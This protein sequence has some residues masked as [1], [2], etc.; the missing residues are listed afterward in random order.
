MADPLFKARNLTKHFDVTQSFFQKLKG[1]EKLKV[2]AV[3]GIDF[4]I[5]Q[6][7]NFSIVGESGCGKTTVGKLM[8]RLL[9][10]T[11]G[12]MYMKDKDIADMDSK[13]QLKAYRRTTQIIYQDPFSALDPRDRIRTILEEPLMIHNLGDTREERTDMVKEALEEVRLTPPEKFLRRYPHM[14]SGGQKQ[15]VSLARA[16][17][18]NPDFIVADEPVSMLDVSVR[19]EILNLMKDL[20]EEEDVT[21][22]YITHDISTTRFFTDYIGVMYLGDLV[23]KGRVED[24][25]DN[26][27]HP[28]TQA[29]LVAVPEPDPERGQ[30]VKNVPITGDVPSATQ[31]PSGCRF[32]PRCPHAEEICKKEEPE[33]KEIEKEHTAKCHFAGEIEFDLDVAK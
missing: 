31:V 7:R 4:D 15:R 21:Y 25:L 1:E 14:L 5:Y 12:H 3:D 6:K 23:E 13:Q 33:E 8:M 27:M 2:R 16:M 18:L 30:G 24:V 10:P 19:A 17:I 28:Y 32:H 20:I 9:D 22:F 11:D 29:L 26:P